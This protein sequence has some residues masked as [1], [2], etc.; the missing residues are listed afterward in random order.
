MLAIL[1]SGKFWF[2]MFV[3]VVLIS[4]LFGVMVQ[5]ILGNERL[6]AQLI[7]ENKNL[8]TACVLAV[9]Q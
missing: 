2:G 6:L 5:N 9:F 8:A 1:K 7:K 4:L 3:G